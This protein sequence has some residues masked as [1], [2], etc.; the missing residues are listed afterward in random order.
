MG[1]VIGFLVGL[2]LILFVGKTKSSRYHTIEVN[3]G[4]N[5]NA[6]SSSIDLSVVTHYSSSTPFA[7]PL[8]KTHPFSL[9]FL[10]SHYQHASLNKQ[11]KLRKWI[12]PIML[13]VSST[14]NYLLF[15]MQKKR[16]DSNEV[17][18]NLLLC[19]MFITLI[20]YYVTYRIV[21]E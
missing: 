5:V 14:I 7:M 9:S 6:T 12:T 18:L 2:Y 10:R 1:L 8:P 4:A 13:I 19:Y 3:H 20:I 16:L 15:P 17:K 11:V 21:L